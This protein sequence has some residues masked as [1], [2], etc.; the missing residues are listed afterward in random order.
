MWWQLQ[1]QSVYSNGGVIDIAASDL[2]EPVFRHIGSKQVAL[3]LRA[4]KLSKAIQQD[5]C[6]TCGL[7]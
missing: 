4:Q 1:L 2:G 7:F 3:R 5:G 6:K